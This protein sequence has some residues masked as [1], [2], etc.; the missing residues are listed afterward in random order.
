MLLS[1][2][3]CQRFYWVSLSDNRVL[4]LAYLSVVLFKYVSMCTYELSSLG[5]HCR[6]RTYRKHLYLW[7]TWIFSLRDYRIVITDISG[8]DLGIL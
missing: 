1:R 3:C 7:A 5:L 2:N 6:G 8:A 4:L